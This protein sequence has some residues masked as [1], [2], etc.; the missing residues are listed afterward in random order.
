MDSLELEIYERYRTL[1]D[2]DWRRRAPMGPEKPQSVRLRDLLERYDAFCFD[3]YGTL[4]NRGSFV[5]DGALEG[6]RMLRAAGKHLRLVT[7]AA[8]NVDRVLAE[9]AASRGFNFTEAE[10]ISSGCLAG[11][12]FAGAGRRI[13]E[14]YYIGRSTGVNV[15]K[16]FGVEAVENPRTSAV[17]VS[18]ATADDAMFAKAVEILKR[19]GGT[20]IVLNSDAWAPKIDGSRSPV[21]GALAERLRRESKCAEVH[22]FGKPFAGIFGRVKAS[23]PADA[24]IL[25]VG[26]TLGTDVMGARYAGIASALIVGRNEPAAELAEDEIALGIR[27]DYYLEG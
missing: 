3:G 12:F 2:P 22:Y 9:E 1:M 27:P 14:V 13:E 5:Y 16:S 25:M 21:S 6:F 20:L 7:N 23:L 19:P 4:Y 18:S 8:S 10:T 11:E 26:D 15:L 17:A 24:R